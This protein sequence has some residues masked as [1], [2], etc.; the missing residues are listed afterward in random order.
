MGTWGPAVF[1]DD[2]ACDV[3]DDW[4]GHVGDGLSAVEATDRLL[5]EWSDSIDEPD[6]GPVIWLALAATQWKAG[7][8]EDR[9]KKKALAIIDDGFRRA[10]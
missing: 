8:L 5:S 7:R 4:R 10:R 2:T 6:D 1:S 9:V 3:R